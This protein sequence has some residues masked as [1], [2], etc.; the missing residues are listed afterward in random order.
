MRLPTPAR[1]K[2]LAAALVLAAPV[3]GFPLV[4]PSIERAVRARL[5]RQARALGLSDTIGTVHLT[6]GLSL[7]IGDVVVEKP[8]RVRILTHSVV[9]GPRL[10]PLGLVGRAAHVVTGR[11]LAELPGGVRLA[12]EPADWVVESR[13]REVVGEGVSIAEVIEARRASRGARPDHG[14]ERARLMAGVAFVFLDELP[15]TEDLAFAAI[16][17]NWKPVYL[18]L[19]RLDSTDD[20]DLDLAIGAR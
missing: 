10:S 8:G 18:D 15:S 19:V 11:V 20:P 4:R 17:G 7:E 14:E 1:R 3:V 2:L 13:W 16:A 9:V 6:P 12:F 5:D